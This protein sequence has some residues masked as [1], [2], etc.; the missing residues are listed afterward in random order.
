MIAAFRRRLRTNR[1][2]RDEVTRLCFQ[3]QARNAEI[4]TLR[5]RLDEQTLRLT[6][7]LKKARAATRAA[8][9]RPVSLARPVGAWTA[10]DSPPLDDDADP[11]CP[12]CPH[13]ATEH[14]DA[15]CNPKASSC[16]CTR[17]PT[18]GGA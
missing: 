2:L 13:A 18:P 7:D 1:Q 3:L 16:D 5:K 15:G 17:P 6:G 14:S 8:T 12:D 4:G 11:L 9:L 10:V